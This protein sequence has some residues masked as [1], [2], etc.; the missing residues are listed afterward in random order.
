M[1]CLNIHKSGR[2]MLRIDENF[3]GEVEEILRE[4]KAIPEHM[5]R[6]LESL[7]FRKAQG[8]S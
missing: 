5:I 6:I 8:P 7:K 1:A 4:I 2:Q 3:L